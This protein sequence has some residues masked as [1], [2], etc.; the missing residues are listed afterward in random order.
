MK[1]GDEVYFFNSNRILTK[2]I[3]IRYEKGVY[4]INSGKRIYRRHAVAIGKVPAGFLKK[5]G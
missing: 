5:E 2:G 3:I 1:R 4:F